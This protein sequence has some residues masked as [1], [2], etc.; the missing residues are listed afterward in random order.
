VSTTTAS[1][2]G[3]SGLAWLILLVGLALAYGYSAG[4]E[5]PSGSGSGAK[6][7]GA[8]SFDPCPPDEGSSKL[9]ET[10]GKWQ[11]RC[12][13]GRCGW[14]HIDRHH[15]PAARD[16]IL[17]IGKVLARGNPQ[18][19]GQN[20]RYQWEFAPG[21]YAVVAVKPDTGTISTAFTKGSGVASARWADCVKRR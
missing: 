19:T 2:G 11:L 21:D 7:G 15:G 20:I 8:A 4:G 6:A 9:V 14:R 17:C 13:T 18:L 3:S 16:T 10:F 5:L 12:G 1:K